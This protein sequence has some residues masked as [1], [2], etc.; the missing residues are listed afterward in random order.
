MNILHCKQG[1]PEW[2]E[3]RLG[4]VSA[5]R[6]ADVI[7]GKTTKRYKNYI[8]E[9]TSDLSGAPF[10]EDDKPWFNHGKELEP[11]AKKRYEFEMFLKGQEI[12]AQEIGMI[13]HPHYDFI[14][15]SPDGMMPTKGLELKSSIS[16][17]N[18]TKMAEK[19]LPSNHKPQVQGCL[20]VSGLPEWDFVLF[21]HD[22]DGLKDDEITITTVRP[23]L[24]YHKML[25]K[26]CLEFYGEAQEL[27]ERYK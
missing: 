9:I 5:S 22:P 4:K 13:I 2:H 11:V 25:E 23:D 26:R 12:D 14:S 10:M 8:A 16:Y 7:A 3:A 17:A 1:S 27:A 6:F 21:F 19:G 24:E 20:W 18:Y 15:C